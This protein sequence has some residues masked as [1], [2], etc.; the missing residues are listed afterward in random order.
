MND[1]SRVYVWRKHS[2]FI[3]HA[4]LPYCAPALY[5]CTDRNDPV[6]R[7]SVA[8]QNVAYNQPTGVGFFIGAELQG[9]GRKFR[10]WQF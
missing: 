1:V 9:C 4:F 5:Q 3:K 6:Y 7:A 8:A 10:G 2:T